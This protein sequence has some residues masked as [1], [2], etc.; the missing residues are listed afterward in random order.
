M[1]HDIDNSNNKQWYD[2]DA[3]DETSYSFKEYDV[4]SAPNDFNTK[5][6][7]DFIE[8]GI[9]KIP[10]FQR[11]YVWDLKR[12]SKLIES[13][14]IGLP[15]PQVFLYEE[16]KNSYLVIDG[17]QRLLTLYFFYKKR[18][19]KKEKRFELR[20]IFDENGNFPDEVLHNDEYFEDFKLKLNEASSTEKNKLHGMSYPTLGEFKTSFDL[21]TV[22]NI[23][24]KQNFPTDDDSA[25]FEIFNR[26]NSGGVVLKPQEIRTSLYHSKFYNY[27]YKLN[28][29][30]NW[31]TL[32]NKS[33]P[34][35][36]MKDVEIL[37]RGFAMLLDS[38]EYKPSMT[39]FL[40]QFSKKSRTFKEE[41]L[42]YFRQLFESFCKKSVDIN[43]KMFVSK[44]GKFSITVFESIF[45]A[46][47]SD[48]VSKNNLNII[49]VTNDKI[50]FLKSKSDFIEASQYNTAGKLNVEQ[51]LRIAKQILV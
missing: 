10:G 41:S 12:A 37:L 4:S 33:E 42:S 23:M 36:H 30:N 39:R 19:P 50:E 5:T 32:L 28:L 43:P 9:F 21:R 22:R 25:M 48:A 26:L 8:S 2:D 29:D 38:E 47:C 27:L 15:I 46:L 20:Q 24:I 7:I 13:I 6:I 35:I 18:F 49:D 51:R 45:V 17:Q 34:D 1:T 40:N 31:R 16:S 11:N 44:S 14:I 3:S